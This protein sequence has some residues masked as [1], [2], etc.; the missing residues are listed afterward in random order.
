VAGA[1]GVD[2]VARPRS[3]HRVDILAGGQILN[4]PI[5]E[6][7]VLHAEGYEGPS[8]SDLGNG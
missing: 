3:G 8:R 1:A 6:V 4:W 2:L 7:F 5:L